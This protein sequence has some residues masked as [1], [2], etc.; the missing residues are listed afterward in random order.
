[1]GEARFSDREHLLILRPYAWP[2]SWHDDLRRAFP[3]L[4][5]TALEV[6]NSPLEE[7]IPK[8]RLKSS[9]LNLLAEH[10]LMAL[11]DILADATIIAFGGRYLP[12]PE[13]IP[14]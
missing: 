4:R 11:A 5:I 1:M 3:T 13:S 8:G 14:K 6:E 10:K 2:D 7:W 9:M 12:L